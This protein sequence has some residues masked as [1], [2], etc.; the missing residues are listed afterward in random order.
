[1]WRMTILRRTMAA[2]VRMDDAGLLTLSASS[3]YPVQ[4]GRYRE[5]LVHD[6]DAVRI[7]ADAVLLNHDPD[8]LVGSIQRAGLGP[9]RRIGAEIKLLPDAR[10]ASGV[11]VADA[12]ASGA[13]RGVSIGYAI[14]E[15]T[16]R[17]VDGIIELR[18]TKWTIREISLTPI[19][20]DPT[21]GVGRTT[22]SDDAFE[23][24]AEKGNKMSDTVATTEQPV[25]VAAPATPDFSAI[26]ADAAK[27]ASQAESLGLRASEFIGMPLAEA[28]DA[29]LEAVA[30]RG[31]SKPSPVVQIVADELPKRVEEAATAL[32]QGRSIH[33]IA[34]RFALRGGIAGAGEWGKQDVAEYVL[35][36]KRAAEVS[37]NFNQVTILASQ[38]AMIGG[39]DSY[40]P[41]S[42][43]LVDTITTNDFKTVRVA[44]LATGDF[45]APGEGVAM[46]DM[47]IDD[48]LTGSGNLTMRGRGLEISKEAIY[49]DELGLFFRKLSQIGMMGRR[50]EDI[51]FATA[52]AGAN[53][54][55]AAL[56]T[57]A[58]DATSLA[59]AWAAFVNFTDP[60]SQKLGVLP[61]FLVVP[62]A[63]YTTAVSLTTLNFG[64]ASTAGLAAVAGAGDNPPL[65]VVVGLHLTDTN[66]W[67]L[68]ADPMQAGGFTKVKHVD[69]PTPQIFEVDPGLVASRKFRIEYPLAIITATSVAN[70]PVGW[71][72]ATVA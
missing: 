55:A 71:G 2:E 43:V 48:N 23:R 21:V 30:K 3:E 57:A 38:K 25:T 60:A 67:Y 4:R 63:L 31:A 1:M 70:Q 47:T 49:N 17:E 65:R 56:G 10:T 54:T 59:V 11:S 20:A 26:R 18:A 58:L 53:F 37:A 66:D 24:F 51:S 15:H 27:I 44:G 34:R 50:H 39:Y 16:R 12:V 64:G 8:Q 45:A 13:L 7:A 14:D 69:Y 28:K 9:D 29:M 36:G 61:K 68:A 6:K 33:E 62:P 5:I 72:K 32:V 40:T 35:G 22:E 42:D 19:P 41:W 46:G 52:L